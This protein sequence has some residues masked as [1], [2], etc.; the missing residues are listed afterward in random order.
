MN[1]CEKFRHEAL[2]LVTLQLEPRS[3]VMLTVWTKAFDY[4]KWT[5]SFQVQRFAAQ[6]ACGVNIVG[7][8][9]CG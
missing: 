6:Q 3:E 4:V 1:L 8:C 2:L 5:R 9:A 7:F